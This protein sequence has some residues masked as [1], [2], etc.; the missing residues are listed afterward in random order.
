MKILYLCLCF[1]GFAVKGT[2][3]VYL[4][5]DTPFKLRAVVI[6]AN[7]ANMGEKA[8]NPQ[9]DTYVEDQLGGS[10]P[11]GQGHP[12]N[13]QNYSSSLTPYTVFWYCNDG[14]LYSSCQNVAAGATVSANGCEGSKYCKPPKQQQEGQ[15]QQGDSE[16]Q[17]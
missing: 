7:G 11:V 6:A 1:L 8:M 5:N 14:T 3:S 15:N 4:L 17:E 12:Q 16:Y 13:F 10:D 2:A 9:E